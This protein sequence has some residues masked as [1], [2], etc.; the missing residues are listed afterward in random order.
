MANKKTI[1]I[2]KIAY[3]TVED[4][5][6]EIRNIS[7]FYHT[8]MAKETD[9][10]IADVPKKAVCDINEFRNYKIRLIDSSGKE[11]V[12]A[13]GGWKDKNDLKRINPMCAEEI[14]DIW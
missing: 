10:T 1:I 2:S 14:F 7:E 4:K 8:L 3:I 12:I 6:Y 9:L 5:I 11:N 13:I